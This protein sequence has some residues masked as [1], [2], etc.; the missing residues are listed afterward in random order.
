M[1]RLAGA[2]PP[3]LVYARQWQC[4]VCAESVPPG[5]HL[6]ATAA[7]RP[8]GSNKVL[9]IDVK[10]LKDAI[11]NQLV[12]LSM[13]DAGTGWHA[14][15][16]LKNRRAKHVARVLMNEW[17]KHYGV[18]ESIIVGQGGEFESYFNGILEQFGIN[19]KM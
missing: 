16:F 9:V 6:L 19:S 3:A 17:F 11:E 18:P 10:Y 8:Y 14:A 13:V 12:A 2:T 15:A 5:R 4:P 1:L 7:V